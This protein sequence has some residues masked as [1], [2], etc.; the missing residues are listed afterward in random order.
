VLIVLGAATSDQGANQAGNIDHAPAQ[1]SDGS[2]RPDGSGKLSSVL[3]ANPLYQ[4]GGLANG[5]CP[6]EDLGNASAEDQ[7]RFYE[8]LLDCLDSEWAPPLKDAG[9]SY[10]SP[11][12][13]AFESAVTTPCGKASPED[14]RTLAFYCP[15]D[16]VMY[17]DIPQMRKFFGDLDVAYAILIGHEFGHHVQQVAGVLDGY[18]QAVYDDYAQRLVL[19]RRVELQ[20]SCMG[21]LFLGAVAESFPIDDARF[22]QL[23][24][25][26]ESFGD[27]PEASENQRDHGNGRSNRTWILRAF[28]DNDIAVCNTFVAPAGQVD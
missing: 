14:G 22:A 19:S 6:A 16:A 20:A 18:D 28:G 13:V 11:D 21:G 2:S 1:P 17:A 4:Q 26:A 24:R 10:Q 5:D 25:V 3:A 23:Q 9:F 27:A 7:T 15:S 8:S 12:L